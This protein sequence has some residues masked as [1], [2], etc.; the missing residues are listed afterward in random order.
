MKLVLNLANPPRPVCKKFQRP[1]GGEPNGTMIVHRLS[2][3]GSSNLE[4]LEN[5]D[6]LNQIT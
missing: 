2:V 5:L 1:W 3:R 4:G 6:P